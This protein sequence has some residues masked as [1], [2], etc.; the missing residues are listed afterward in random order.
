MKHYTMTILTLL[1]D[2]IVLLVFI[3]RYNYNHLH[4]NPIT[5]FLLGTGFGIAIINY[6]DDK[7]KR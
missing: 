4:L 5:P 6:L 7:Y 2:L 1:I 3:V